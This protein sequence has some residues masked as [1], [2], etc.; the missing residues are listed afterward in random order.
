MFNKALDAS[1]GRPLSAKPARSGPGTSAPEIDPLDTVEL[2]GC[3]GEPPGAA[4]AFAERLWGFKAGNP[5]AAGPEGGYVRRYEA[6]QPTRAER[7]QPKRSP[8]WDDEGFVEPAPL[9]TGN[10]GGKQPEKQGHRPVDS[11]DLE[12]LDAM[13]AECREEESLKTTQPGGSGRGRQT[14]TQSA[15]ALPESER[16]RGMREPFGAVGWNGPAEICAFRSGNFCGNNGATCSGQPPGNS[17]EGSAFL[18]VH[19]SVDAEAPGTSLSCA[20]CGSEVAAVGAPEVTKTVLQKSFL[21]GLLER[22]RSGT[23]LPLADAS[24]G[25]GN[26]GGLYPIEV[27]VV[28]ASELCLQRRQ[29]TDS[30]RTVGEQSVGNGWGIWIEKDG[31]VFEPVHCPGCGSGGACVGAKV[32][33]A[34]KANSYFNGQVRMLAPGSGIQLACYCLWDPSTRDTLIVARLTPILFRRAIAER[35]CMFAGLDIPPP[36][37]L[38]LLAANVTERP[39]SDQK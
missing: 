39:L 17:L 32:L 30:A 8:F 31:C 19:G 18:G 15:S 1:I 9:E 26:G 16:N 3:R 38:F 28:N 33:A 11:L 6:T 5:D 22:S 20:R 21:Q 29:G 10:S 12:T 14:G 34:D 2:S 27:L 23:V 4:E 35:G 13:V 36:S 37:S 25:I 7:R 24:T